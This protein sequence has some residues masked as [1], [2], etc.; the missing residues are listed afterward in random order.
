MS[1]GWTQKVWDR[2]G[3]NLPYNWGKSRKT[4]VRVAEVLDT[5][6][7]VDL[8]IFLGAASTGLLSIRPPR[9]TVG[10]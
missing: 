2:F 4:S 3:L 5:N 7:C 6:R 8:A 9:I 10:D 1:G